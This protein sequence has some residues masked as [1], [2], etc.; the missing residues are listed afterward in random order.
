MASSFKPLGG[1]LS[2]CQLQSA[3]EGFIGCQLQTPGR[4]LSC[5]QLQSPAWMSPRTLV[6]KLRAWCV[7]ASI[8]ALPSEDVQI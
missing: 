6:V 5:G 8:V 3:G 4:G 7:T 2:D 1:A